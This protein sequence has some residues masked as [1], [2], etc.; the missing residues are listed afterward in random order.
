MCRL[1]YT[2]K[3][4]RG[5]V[6]IGGIG[7]WGSKLPQLI[8]GGWGW[9]RSGGGGAVIERQHRQ[10]NLFEAVIGSVEALIEELIEPPLRRLDAVLADEALLEAVMQGLARR[11]PQRRTR[12]RPGTPGEVVLRMLVLK[13]VKGWS[14]EETEHAVRKNL[15][16]RHLARVYC[17]RVP[18]AETLMRL[19]NVIG[20]E[21]VEAIH[22]RLV[23]MAR[24]KGLSKGRYARVDTTVVETNIRYPTD[25]RLLQDGVRGL[26][27]TFKRIERPTGMMG[28]KLR[29][30]MRA[31]THRVLEIAR[32]ARSR[33]GQGRERLEQGY[34][35]LLSTVR[36]TVR[37]AARVC[38]ATLLGRA[39][40]G[41]R[42]GV[43]CG[44]GQPRTAGTVC[45]PGAPGNRSDPSADLS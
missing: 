17:A 10:R 37:D 11:R 24:E 25:S 2:M 18:D 35:R 16:Y 5:L 1:S 30:R 36:S 8:C 43:A 32:A 21:G 15:V 3:L 6:R 23:Q 19:L 9:A 20:A 26:T 14:F 39:R 40:R 12:G 42:A 33:A 29:D 44:G 13:R 31:T 27:R 22:R 34:R 7:S 28:S 41:P 38:A 4:R 45:A